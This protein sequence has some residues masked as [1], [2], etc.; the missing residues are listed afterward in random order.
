MPAFPEL[1]PGLKLACEWL[2]DVAQVRADDDLPP[3]ARKHALR[4]WAGSF[5]G[6]YTAWNRTWSFTGP[7][8]HAGQA[9]KALLLARQATGL[10]TLDAALRGG[11]FLLANTVTAGP[12]AGLM[13]GFEDRPDKLNT[14]AILEAL[15]AGF[16]I[17]A[18]PGVAEWLGKPEARAVVTELHEFVTKEFG[19]DRQVCL[20]PQSRGGLLC[21]N[22]AAEHPDLVRCIG[23]IYPVLD[24]MTYPA[25][26]HGPKVAPDTYGMSIEEFARQLPQH[27]PIER[28][29]PLAEKKIPIF[30]IHGDKDSPVPAKRNSLEAQER[31][32]ALGGEMEV[33]IV[34]GIG[35]KECPEIFHSQRL[36]DFF[37]KHGLSPERK[38]AGAPEGAL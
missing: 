27:N 4:C 23:G 9:V 12:D 11:R 32:R 29:A 19:L 1:V 34:P 36:L 6:N 25:G 24:M 37:L 31:Y 20:M 30:H 17:A 35:H 18:A 21:Y 28:L 2:T 3:A 7:T 22:W 14:S 38:V 33:E 15:D 8:W 13:L 16:A 5:R 10:D 26:P